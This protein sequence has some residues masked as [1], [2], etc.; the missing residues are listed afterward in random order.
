MDKESGV[1]DAVAMSGWTRRCLYGVVVVVKVEIKL[2][3]QIIVVAVDVAV[4]LGFS[5]HVALALALAL[6]VAI[7]GDV[8]LEDAIL[9]TMLVSKAYG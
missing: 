8:L 5:D 4:K 9:H 7:R 3:G 6:A 1:V 2:L